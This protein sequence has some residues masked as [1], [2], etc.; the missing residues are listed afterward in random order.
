MIRFR[1]DL[2]RLAIAIAVAT[3]APA[4]VTRVVGHVRDSTGTP[5]A[6]AQVTS[7]GRRTITD[8]AGRFALEGLPI[9]TIV[10]NFRRLGFGP[11]DSSMTLAAGPSDS[12]AVIL[13]ALPLELEG[14]TTEAGRLVLVDFYRHKG[15]GGG[16]RF[17][18]R[19]QIE[20][21]HVETTSDVMRRVPGVTLVPDRNGRFELR[22]R[23]NAGTCPPDFWIDGV[24]A[25]FL[26][27]DDLPLNDIE[28]LEI[29][30]GSSGLPPE[31]MNR[32]GHPACGAVV[33]WTRLPG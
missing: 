30:N 25:P 26:N 11:H 19:E 13:V 7:V 1:T 23:G 31:Y 2:C 12:V 24:R 6:A 17:F 4:Q 9:G 8:S 3:P 18:D 28:A 5:I 33:I 10:I 20:A 22:M 29:Y 27:V 15:T 16:G 14:I 21:F 32:F